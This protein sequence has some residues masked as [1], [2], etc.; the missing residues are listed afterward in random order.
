[1]LRSERVRAHLVA[2]G[3]GFW[4]GLTLLLTWQALRA[5][6]LIAPDAVTLG[7]A[8]ALVVVTAGAAAVV[9]AR[10]SRSAPSAG[11]HTPVAV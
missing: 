5:Q 1:V 9:L 7:V 3:A 2:V 10:G 11:R 8:A 4:V 6:P